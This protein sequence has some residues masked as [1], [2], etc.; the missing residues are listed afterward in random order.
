MLT[1]C[2]SP[3]RSF[4]ITAFVNSP[5]LPSLSISIPRL[6]YTLSRNSTSSTTGSF[7][8][9][10]SDAS[11][12][13]PCASSSENRAAKS[14]A[15]DAR[16][17]PSISRSEHALAVRNFWVSRRAISD[18]CAVE[19]CWETSSSCCEFRVAKVR[20]SLF[21]CEL[22]SLM[23]RSR[24]DSRV[25]RESWI[26]ETATRSGWMLKLWMVCRIN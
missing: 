21:N 7:L 22:A 23:R 6:L 16:R 18:A 5:S 2:T 10:F 8:L 20:F 4:R 24:A 14:A 11:P 25:P 1:T 17:S 9:A 26:R 19:E 15:V 3:L 13:T 12:S